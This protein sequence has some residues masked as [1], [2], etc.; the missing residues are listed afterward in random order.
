MG[1][2]NQWVT[3]ALFSRR[4]GLRAGFSLLRDVFKLKRA[5][6]FKELFEAGFEAFR[7]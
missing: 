7:T 1:P 5:D 6:A 2:S 4:L 3:Q